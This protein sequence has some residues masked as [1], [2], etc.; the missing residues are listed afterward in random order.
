M[1]HAVPRVV[2]AGCQ[3]RSNSI[4]FDR[5]T[6]GGRKLIFH[7]AL[8][9]HWGFLLMYLRKSETAENM[10]GRC[11]VQRGPPFL[12]CLRGLCGEEDAFHAG[13]HATGSLSLLP[14]ELV[15]VS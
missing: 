8:V 13:M 2:H 7:R 11:V 4:E 9:P 12:G 5:M 14:N 3:I 1:F 10:P 6:R 15:I